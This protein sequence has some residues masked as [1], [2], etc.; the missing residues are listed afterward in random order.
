MHPFV[1]QYLITN[2]V[3][4][5]REDNLTTT[6]STTTTDGYKTR[7]E[8][9]DWTIVRDI[10]S[11]HFGALLI[12]MYFWLCA[13]SYFQLVFAFRYERYDVYRAA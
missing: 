13:Y 8:R 9:Y 12:N 3:N 7:C 4:M 5:T 10:M 6:E 11:V 1:Q 2:N